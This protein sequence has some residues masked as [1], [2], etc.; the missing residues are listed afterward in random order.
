[1]EDIMDIVESSEESGLPIK[2]INEIIKNEAKEQKGDFFPILLG[3]LAASILG[4]ALKGQ[5]VIRTGEGVIRAGPNFQCSPILQLILKSKNII[6]T[7]L[8]L[9]VFMQEIIHLK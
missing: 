7:N 6:K 3:T 8:N 4:N 2:E 9:M 5:G 1:M